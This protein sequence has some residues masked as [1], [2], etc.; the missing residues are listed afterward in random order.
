MFCS[1]WSQSDVMCS[2]SSR[3]KRTSLPKETSRTKC[4]SRS[5]CGTHRSKQKSTALAV[6]FCLEAPPGIEPGIE[7][8]QTFALPLGH[9]AVFIF[10]NGLLDLDAEVVISVS[11]P[12]FVR[13]KRRTRLKNTHTFEIRKNFFLFFLSK[14]AITS[15]SG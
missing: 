6:L 5:A 2:A 13:Q 9:S 12:Y 15:V 3:A 7:V 4:T 10:Y 8:L 14:P 11:S 1:R